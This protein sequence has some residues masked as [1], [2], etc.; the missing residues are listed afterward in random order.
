MSALTLTFY[1]ENSPNAS[2]VGT[3]DELDLR[4]FEMRV[5]LHELG[6]GRFTLNRWH[7]DSDLI[8]PNRLVKVT[9]PSVDDNPIFAFWLTDGSFELL[10]EGGTGDEVLTFGGP[11][12]MF[13]LARARLYHSSL[14]YDQPARGSLNEDGMWTW[15]DE[16]WGAILTR[17]IEEGR[18]NPFPD[19]A[20]NGSALEHVTIDFSRTVDS[21]SVAWPNIDEEYK[22]PIGTDMLSVAEKLRQAGDLYLEMEPNM[23]FHAR[24]TYGRNLAGDFDID[25]VR[26]EKAINIKTALLRE[27]QAQ[28]DGTHLLQK[29]SNGDYSTEVDPSY[30]TAKQK[31]WIYT[32]QNTNDDNTLNALAQDEIRRTKTQTQKLRWEIATGFDPDN[33]R[34]M[35]GPEG[36]D[37]HFWVGDTVTLHTGTAPHD[38]DEEDQLVTGINVVLTLAKDGDDIERARSF[39]VEVELNFEGTRQM[40]FQDGT[41][42]PSRH[43]HFLDL[44]TALIPGTEMV[45]RW[46]HS[47]SDTA[48]DGEYEAHP[49]WETGGGILAVSNEVNLLKSAPD[50]SY[51]A[52]AQ[53]DV[54]VGVNVS[55][56]DYKHISSFGVEMDSTLAEAIAAG[57]AS[58][59]MQALV[60]SR[61]GIGISESSQNNIAQLAVR[62]WRVGSGLVG[63]ALDLGAGMGTKWPAASTKQN[64]NWSGILNAVED[65][66]SG[67]WLVVDAGTAHLGPTS[68]GTG[69]YIGLRSIVD[70]TDL[71]EGEGEIDNWNSW[72][73]LRFTT[74][75]IGDGMHP[76]LVGTSRSAARCDHRHHIL[77]DRDPNT[78][79][80]R[81]HGY[82]TTTL[83]TNTVSGQSFLL[84]DEDAGT[85]IP[86]ATPESLGDHTHN[87]DDVTY[88]PTA[89]GLIADTVQEAIDELTD[90]VGGGLFLEKAD[91]ENHNVNVVAATGS[92]ET[93]DLSTGNF[94]DFTLDDDCTF[95]MPTPTAGKRFY[96][97]LRQD[98]TGGWTPTFTD[99]EWPDDTPP[100]WT[101]DPDTLDIVEFVSDAMVWYGFAGG[102]GGSSTPTLT[103]EEIDGTPTEGTVDTLRFPADTLTEPS[104][105]EVTY[106]PVSNLIFGWDN[107]NAP[108]TTAAN[109][110]DIPID[111]AFDIEQVTM[112]AV[113]VSGSG[114]AVVDLGVDTYANFPPA[115]DSIVA[116]APPTI[117]SAI[118]SQ[119]ATLTGWTTALAAGSTLRAT[120]TSI[121]GLKSLT[122]GLKLRRK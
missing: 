8:V 10:K 41:N 11:G 31:H 2:P 34:Y 57:G 92:A 25:T 110:I 1:E 111:A 85:W 39:R 114:S 56:G 70:N 4:A 9:I 102:S 5:G 73:E 17:I 53:A 3:L 83:W 50:G 38:Y 23:Q 54:M 89:S 116:S 94:Q 63:T 72:V 106:K 51:G 16:P 19:A 93:I 60:R 37:G 69:A 14:V 122:I 97:F 96:A 104:A 21:D 121:S 67:D 98:G 78:D 77:S 120:L 36:T 118:K 45:T 29:D 52:T 22:E 109:P 13:I 82:P 74:Q 115:P 117:S 55:A 65:A 20:A 91:G 112:L 64:R 88:D 66:V 76:D 43:T 26:F 79:D 7:E 84:V 30:T 33:G 95:T 75:P 62:V 61:Y 108:L 18:E 59:V 71:P 80:D 81:T 42:G 28:S 15:L 87:A 90:T 105:G 113:P 68:G 46:Y 6:W 101:T 86:F 100:E 47:T 24:Q 119:D 58:L 40:T 48:V 107:G 35:P 27:I 99:V 49:D 32:E 103:V 12:I 44:C